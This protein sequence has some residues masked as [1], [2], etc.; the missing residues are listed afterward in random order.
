MSDTFS[1]KSGKSVGAK[2][3]NY[4]IYSRDE[5]YES[6]FIEGFDIIEINNFTGKGSEPFKE[7]RVKQRLAD[8]YGG[9]PNDWK[10][11][12]GRGWIFEPVTGKIREA[13]VHWMQNDEIER[14]EEFVFK[15]W[16][17]HKK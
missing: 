1:P 13:E 7:L 16:I 5:G 6:S 2:A 14:S 3:L 10:H 11:I 9:N 17:E 4:T 8:E 15:N 12:A